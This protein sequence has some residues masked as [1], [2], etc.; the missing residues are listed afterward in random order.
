[1]Q[2]TSTLETHTLV[3]NQYKTEIEN[4][5]N[6]KLDLEQKCANYK[7]EMLNLKSLRETYP[8]LLKEALKFVLNKK[9]KLVH[10][11][12]PFTQEELVSIQ[13]AFN[14]AGVDLKKQ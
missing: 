14:D 2:K 1:M 7:S 10:S 11:L 5:A 12:K 3:M 9:H 6:A 4:M 13:E 8:Y